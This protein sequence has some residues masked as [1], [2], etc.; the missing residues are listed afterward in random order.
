[1][2]QYFQFELL[3]EIAWR[4]DQI[5]TSAINPFMIILIVF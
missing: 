1:M 5:F 4:V 3:N 2:Y